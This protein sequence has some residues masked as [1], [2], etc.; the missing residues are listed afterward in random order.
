MRRLS[1]TVSVLIRGDLTVMADR[2]GDVDATP[3]DRTD[4]ATG[5]RNVP[6]IS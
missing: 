2:R 3:V 1:G 6:A 4:G 5:F